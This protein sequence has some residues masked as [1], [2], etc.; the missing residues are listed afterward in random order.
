MKLQNLLSAVAVVFALSAAASAQESAFKA[1]QAVYVV[2][3]TSSGQ[4]DLSTLLAKSLNKE[5]MHFAQLN[6]KGLPS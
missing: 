2:V 4:P 1:G 5:L 3:M 6:L